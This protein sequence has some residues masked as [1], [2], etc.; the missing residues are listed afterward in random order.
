MY[1]LKLF[2]NNFEKYLKKTSISFGCSL[3]P[4]NDLIVTL[5]MKKLELSHV[6][7]FSNM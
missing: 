5:Y 6:G 1:R 7:N 3:G 4:R 2:F